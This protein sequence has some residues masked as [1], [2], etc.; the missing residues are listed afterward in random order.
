MCKTDLSKQLTTIL[1]LTDKRNIISSHLLLNKFLSLEGVS[2]KVANT[3]CGLSLGV[4]TRNVIL[5]R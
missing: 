5:L 4:E 2:R 1:Q 3:L